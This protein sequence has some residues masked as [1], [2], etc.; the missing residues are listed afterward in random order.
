MA[1][2]IERLEY[3]VKNKLLDSTKVNQNSLSG[4]CIF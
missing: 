2:S 4:H 3:T 1:G